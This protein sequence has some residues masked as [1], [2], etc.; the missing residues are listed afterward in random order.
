MSV[1][2]PSGIG[3]PDLQN[4]CQRSTALCF[5]QP[6]RLQPQDLGRT[7]PFLEERHVVAGAGD[8]LLRTQAAVGHPP[9]LDCLPDKVTVSYR[10]VVVLARL[11]A[12][13]G[14]VGAGS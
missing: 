7:G 6:L 5:S 10:W 8:S 3:S 2:E 11:V 14:L 1:W 4:R 13:A 12:Q 9:L